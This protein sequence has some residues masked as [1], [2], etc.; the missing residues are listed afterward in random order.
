[1]QLESARSAI[2][3]ELPVPES[4]CKPDNAKSGRAGQM[5]QSEAAFYSWFGC[6]G[7]MDGSEAERAN[8]P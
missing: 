8:D 3:L 4:R 1:M 2:A 6:N 7:K 5:R